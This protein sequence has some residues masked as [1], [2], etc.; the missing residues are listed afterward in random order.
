MISRVADHCFW[1]GRY[2]ERAESHRAHAAR[3]RCT[4]ALDAELAAAQVLAAGRRR[5]GRGGALRRASPTAT[6]AAW[7]DGEVV[8]RFMVWDEDNGVLARPLDRR[9]ARGTR[10]RSARCCRSRPGR[11]ST[12]CTCGCASDGARGAVRARTATAFYRH[13]RRATQLTL[14]LLRSTM[15]HDEP[16]DFIWLGVLLERV[17]PDRAH[18]RRAPPR[19]HEPAAAPRGRRDRAVAVAAA[20]AVGLRGVHEA[21]RGPGQLRGRS[22]GFLISEPAFPRSIAYCVHSAYDRLCAIRPPERHELPGGAALERLRVLD[23]WVAARQKEPLAGGARPRPADPR[24]RRGR[25]R[26]AGRSASELLGARLAPSAAVQSAPMPNLLAM[27][28]E[29]ELAPSFTL[30]CLDAGPHAAR[31]L[32]PR[33][34]PGAASRRR[35]SSRSPR[36]RRRRSAASSR[37]R[38]S[39]S[40]RRCSCSTSAPRR[41]ARCPTRTR[42]RSRARGAAATG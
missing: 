19:V 24:G 29:G 3:R 4:L 39:R 20:R 7:G 22:R 18:A 36:R 6:T 14:G 31:R 1:F 9:R 26:S 38:G 25:T 32:G 41:G 42:S 5:L 40:R 30:H 37:S 10:A 33:L 21:R 27:S 15:L 28:F 11:R 35:R 13:V 17:E 23:T 34:L 12:S 8:Q 2:L 16:L